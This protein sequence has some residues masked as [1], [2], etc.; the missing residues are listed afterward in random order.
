MVGTAS[1][2]IDFRFSVFRFKE[3]KSA[4]NLL[5]TSASRTSSIHINPRYLS[6]QSEVNFLQ[7]LSTIS[8]VGKCY[9][10]SKCPKFLL[11]DN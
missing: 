6:L 9:P 7:S 10:S 4:T 11:P 2:E 8:A 5:G 3:S 1:S